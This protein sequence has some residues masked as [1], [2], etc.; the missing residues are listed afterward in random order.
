MQKDLFVHESAFLD[1]LNTSQILSSKGENVQFNIDAYVDKQ[2]GTLKLKAINVKLMIT[3]PIERDDTSHA[4]QVATTTTSTSFE[5][6]PLLPA[7]TDRDHPH[8]AAGEQYNGELLWFNESDKFGFIRCDDIEAAEDEGGHSGAD[9][10][11]YESELRFDRQLLF[12]GMR[13]QFDIE[14]YRDNTG[15]QKRKA[16]NVDIEQFDDTHSVQSA[17]HSVH[18]ILSSTCESSTSTVATAAT[19]VT[20]AWQPS[21]RDECKQQHVPLHAPLSYNRLTWSHDKRRSSSSSGSSSVRESAPQFR[22]QLLWYDGHKR[23]G[24]IECDEAEIDDVFVYETDFRFPKGLICNGMRL[25]FDI[26]QYT[27]AKQKRKRKAINVMMDHAWIAAQETTIRTEMDKESELAMEETDVAVDVGGNTDLRLLHLQ[28]QNDVHMNDEQTETETETDMRH[29]MMHERDTSTDTESE[30]DLT[31]MCS[32]FR[33]KD[34]VDA[35]EFVP[36]FTT[37]PRKVVSTA[38]LAVPKALTVPKVLDTIEECDDEHNDENFGDDDEEEEEREEEKEEEEEEDEHGAELHPQRKTKTKTAKR[39][40]KNPHKNNKNQN[41]TTQFL[42]R[43]FAKYG[44]DTA[45]IATEIFDQFFNHTHTPAPVH[46]KS[47]PTKLHK[48]KK[49]RRNS[50]KE[51]Q[52]RP[53]YE[54][55]DKVLTR[56]FEAYYNSTLIAQRIFV[57]VVLHLLSLLQRQSSFLH[58]VRI[59]HHDQG[60]NFMEKFF[61]QFTDVHKYRDLFARY[62]FM[63]LYPHIEATAQIE[64]MIKMQASLTDLLRCDSIQCTNYVS[65]Y[66]LLEYVIPQYGVVAIDDDDDLSKQ[67]DVLLQLLQR[68]VSIPEERDTDDVDNNHKLLLMALLTAVCQRH[69]VLPTHYYSLLE[70][71]ESD[72]VVPFA[73][74][75]K[76]RLDEFDSL[77]DAMS[78]SSESSSEKTKVYG[79]RDALMVLSDFI[80]MLQRREIK[81]NARHLFTDDDDEDDS[82]ELLEFVDDF[83]SSFDETYIGTLDLLRPNPNRNVSKICSWKDTDTHSWND[84]LYV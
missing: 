6:T 78:S 38:S 81:Q 34:V 1:N 56:M 12:K 84:I 44:K 43:L 23:H 47:K 41:A 52:P 10:F 70:R 42:Q 7:S 11:V 76:W 19:A 65:M 28:F 72:E 29:A 33:L 18:S 20:T 40:S 21:F 66:R 13:L 14:L 69:H 77:T 48:R 57:T 46:S 75:E 59:L 27:D 16:V 83:D 35:K 39:K 80:D 25:L 63:S 2:S 60:V 49:H 31:N 4:L 73:V 5:D 8:H 74:I 54:I 36:E 64:T 51:K 45:Q 32:R 37:A 9:L 67:Q 58:L 26:K 79:K 30:S 15:R 55:L 68:M 82:A 3:T 24:F 61:Y 53:T 71:L 50:K 22:G 17:Q 62:G